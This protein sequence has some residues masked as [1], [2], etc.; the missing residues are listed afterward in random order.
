MAGPGDVILKFD[1]MGRD[2]DTQEDRKLASKALFLPRG[3]KVG[4]L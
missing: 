2:P 4:L 3:D 1:V